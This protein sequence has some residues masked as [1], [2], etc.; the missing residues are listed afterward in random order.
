MREAA[1]H[2]AG[3]EERGCGEELCTFC[4]R[5]GAE[6]DCYAKGGLSKPK[7]ARLGCDGEHVTGLHALLGEADAIV[8]LVAGGEGEPVVD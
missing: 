3:R 5:H 1:R 7:C 6:L 4:L 2:E 8:N